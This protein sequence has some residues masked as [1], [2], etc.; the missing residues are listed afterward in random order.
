MIKVNLLKSRAVVGAG[1]GDAA[2]AAQV[3][4]S[5]APAAQSFDLDKG[6]NTFEYSQVGQFLKVVLVVIFVVPLVI[7]EKIR[8]NDSEGEIKSRRAE[9]ETVQKHKIEKE[10]ILAQY[11]G[12]E[13][14]RDVLVL[15]NK[16]L[17]AVKLERLLAVKSVDAIQTAIPEDVWLKTL[18]LERGFVKI[19][20]K[21]LSDT[22]L[23]LFVRNLKKVEFFLNV[24]VPKDIK[25]KD[26]SGRVL[27]EFLVTLNITGAVE[28]KEGGF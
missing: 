21:T 14:K 5:S 9:V 3:G 12:S 26:E 25:K 27:N 11:E 13:K 18:S 7:F 10:E 8:A 28:F 23:D 19:S 22:G 16:E 24:N 1:V 4:A 20:G 2:A 15:R 6:F 17:R